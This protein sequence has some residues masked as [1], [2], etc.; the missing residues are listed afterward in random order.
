MIHDSIEISSDY[1]TAVYGGAVIA[2][3]RYSRHAT[4]DGNGAWIVSTHPARLFHLQ[5]SDHGTNRSLSA[6]QPVMAMMTRSSS[7][8]VPR[9]AVPREGTP[10]LAAVPHC[11]TGRRRRLVGLLGGPWPALRVRSHPP[12]AWYLG[13][14]Y[15]QYRYHAAGRRRGVRRLRHGRLA[16]AR[17]TRVGSEVRQVERHWRSQP[18]NAGTGR[19]SPSQSRPCSAGSVAGRGAR[20]VLPVV[21]LGFGAALSHLLR[22]EG[23]EPETAPEAN[24]EAVPEPLSATAPKSES[25]TVRGTALVDVPASTVRSTP[26]VRRV[27][28]KPAVKR[29]KPVD[30]AMFYAADLEVGAVP[31]LRRIRADLHIGQDKAKQVQTE[32]TAA[33]SL[34]SLPPRPLSRNA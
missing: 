7:R 12:V 10:P 14:R 13:C 27:N 9:S 25:I 1:M 5:P 24:P 11:S 21:V 8:G 34:P 30:P 28:A 23:G 20:I 18:G 22:G 2:T 16:H 3:A 15:G 17:R 33:L 4:T 26:R 32:L 19:L 29:P 31:S 6:W